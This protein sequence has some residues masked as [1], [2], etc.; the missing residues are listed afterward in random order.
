VLQIFRE[1]GAEVERLP[2][3]RVVEREPGGVEEVPLGRKSGHTTSSAPSIHVVAHDRM[4]DRREM[5]ADLVS[6]S[7]MEMRTKKVPRV[8]PGKAYEVGL[9]RPTLID[10]CHALPVSW[11]TSDR[12]LDREGVR[13][14]VPPC[15]DGVPASD[16]AGGQ[17]RAQ[18]A[19]CPVRLG[20]DQQPGGLL[21]QAMHH[22]RPLGV[23]LRGKTSASAQQSVYQS[24]G[25][26]SRRRMHYHARRFVDHEQ[27]LIL[28]NDADRDVFA[29]NRP[30][31]HLGD[32]DPDDFSRLGTVAGFLAPPI[33][34][35][36]ALRDQSRRLRTRE[37]G[38]LGN[39]QIEADIAVRL[40]GKLS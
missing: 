37:F 30:L 20:D 35:Y 31:F 32:L 18:E 1:G 15:H 25:P 8:E 4:A 12:L 27:P 19:V 11:I 3:H 16:P 2:R 14:E 24:P 26:V 23:A 17:S 13:G 9:G 5:N 36:V 29:G 33:D 6:P 22:S 7:G 34:Q 38:P 40:D 28:V 10:D 39:K 21:I